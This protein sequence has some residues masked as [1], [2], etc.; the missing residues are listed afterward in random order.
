MRDVWTPLS[1]EL[2]AWG[3][4]GRTA[5]F[6]WRDDDA[7]VPSRALDRLADLQAGVG[8]PVALAV[9]PYGMDPDLAGWLRAHGDHG[10]IAVLQHGYAHQN[11]G[12]PRQ[13]RVELGPQRPA[14]QVIGE[15][16]QG[17][18]ILER[19]PGARRILV[20]PWNRIAR[21]LIP[22]LPDLG[23][24]GLSTFG[25]RRRAQPV[26][27]LT[28]VNT[29]IDPIDWKATRRFRGTGAVL[30]DAV[31]HLEARR[32][33]TADAVEPTGLLT[34]HL[35]HDSATWSFIASFVG[36]IA[37]HEAARMVAVDDMFARPA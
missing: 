8:V 12:G 1:R 31:A 7:R 18:Q 14:E 35:A 16:A 34:H 23:F 21:H 22:I 32:T 3:A 29:H 10:G 36:H 13:K 9:V 15:L 2:D 24:A 30:A 6:W 20:P 4:A 26:A 5:T 37:A 28:Q 33:G 27:D 19:L 25:A 11:F 17:S